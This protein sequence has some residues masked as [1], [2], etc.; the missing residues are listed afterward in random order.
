MQGFA[1]IAAEALQIEDFLLSG[2]GSMRA[3]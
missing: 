2:S 1:A 3:A